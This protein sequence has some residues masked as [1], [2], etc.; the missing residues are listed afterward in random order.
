MSG[1]KRIEIERDRRI[2]R[3]RYLCRACT[4]K[5][6]WR[7]AKIK[8]AML[9]GVACE[10]KTKMASCYFFNSS[11]HTKNDGKL[12][13]PVNSMIDAKIGWLLVN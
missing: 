6:R 7:L 10:K 1:L 9:L 5:K 12:F 3:E 13:E 8:I 2:N 4:G 11:I